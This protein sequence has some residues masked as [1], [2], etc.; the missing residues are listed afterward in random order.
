MMRQLRRLTHS[1]PALGPGVSAIAVYSEVTPDGMRDRPAAE[2]GFEGVACVDD[3]ARL[4][5]LYIRIWRRYRADWARRAALESLAFVRAMQTPEG[6]FIN[7]LSDW[8]GTK[9]LAGRTSAS[10]TGPW[11]ARACEALA[12]G[13]RAFEDER[14]T[15]ALRRAIPLLRLP[16]PHLD[17]RAVALLAAL[18][19]P[20]ATEPVELAGCASSWAQEIFDSRIGALLPDARDSSAVH[21]WGHLQECALAEAGLRFGR[22]DWTR[23]AQASSDLLLVPAAESAFPEH[24]SIPFDVSCTVRGLESVGRATGEGRY[25]HA[26]QLARAWFD[27]RNAAAT[28]VFDAPRGLV[29]DGIDGGCVNANSGAEA[30]IEYGL[31]LLAGMGARAR[32]SGR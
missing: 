5:C 15:Q 6:G 22:A 31:A 4:A 23:A 1:V 18:E 27:G 32:A 26:S 21:L 8:D 9:N 30:N 28:P 12:A 16:T 3:S 10:P 14:C 24:T 13:G 25:F 17:L 2:S 7:F 11:L 29:H 19:F 20:P